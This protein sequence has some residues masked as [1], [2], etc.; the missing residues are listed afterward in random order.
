M[1]F[2]MKKK[3]DKYELFKIL[4]ALFNRNWFDTFEAFFVSPPTLCKFL[5][6][7]SVLCHHQQLHILQLSDCH[8][9]IKEPVCPPINP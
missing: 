3:K 9:K 7:K 6:R 1:A 2:F 4:S 8:T 5:A